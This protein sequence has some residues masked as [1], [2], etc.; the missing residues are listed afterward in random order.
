[1]S[2]NKADH[3]PSLAF[4]ALQKTLAGDGYLGAILVTDLLGVPQEFRCTYPVKPSLIQRPLYGDTLEPHIGVKLCGIPLLK[5]LQN[6]PSLVIVDD[7]RLLDIRVEGSCPVAYVRRAGEAI[8]VSTPDDARAA[9]NREV[10]SCASGRFQPI[11]I[12]THPDFPDDAATARE[13]LESAFISLDPIEPFARISV[14]VELLGKQD[15]R[16]Q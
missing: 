2:S 13:I 11:V 10:V 6:A 14:S 15:K 1:M 8:E 7:R 12:A 9:A 4:L 16:F 5:A 3:D